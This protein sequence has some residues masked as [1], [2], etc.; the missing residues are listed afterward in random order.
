MQD[1]SRLEHA[2]RELRLKLAATGL[3][4]YSV[5]GLEDLPPPLN[6]SLAVP[7]ARMAS[8]RI[9]LVGHRGGDIWPQVQPAIAT[10]ADPVDD[11]SR[12]TLQRLCDEVLTGY[13][14]RVIFPGADMMPLQQLGDRAGWG[15]SSWLGIN[16]HA[17]FGTWYA[18]RAVVLTSA[19][20]RPETLPDS[21]YPCEKC[22]R[23]CADNCPVTAPAQPG[24]FDLDA[25]VNWRLGPD[26]PCARRCLA[27]ESCPVGVDNRYPPEMIRYFYSRS[28]ESLK[29]WRGE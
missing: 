20:L 10:A 25:C 2:S 17:S 19:P 14:N 27:R 28:L 4:I 6:A 8:S 7:A 23:P 29:R 11:F 12:N 18:F 5:L 3:N 24:S 21:V 9:I 1:H 13:E 22:E 15:K 26:S 16:I